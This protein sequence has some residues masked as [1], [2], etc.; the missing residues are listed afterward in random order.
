MK[1]GDLLIRDYV[2]SEDLGSTNGGRPV[3]AGDAEWMVGKSCKHLAPDLDRGFLMDG[4]RRK[5][6]SSCHFFRANWVLFDTVLQ[7]ERMIEHC[8]T[9]WPNFERNL[10]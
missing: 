1:S 10:E 2:T 9:N 6:F 8:C 3:M 5:V 7:R 4:T